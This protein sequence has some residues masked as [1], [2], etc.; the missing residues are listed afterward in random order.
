MSTLNLSPKNPL[1]L[2]ALAAGAVWFLSRRQVTYA[3]AVRPAPVGTQ[4]SPLAKIID[5]AG[6]IL[7]SL[8]APVFNATDPVFRDPAYGGSTGVTGT[9]A[10]WSEWYSQVQQ[11]AA[12][13]DAISGNDP[14]GDPYWS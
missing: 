7:R 4:P 2:V 1:M 3:G 6:T 12:A 8:S 11:D 13:Q 14:D 5:T 9:W 10:G